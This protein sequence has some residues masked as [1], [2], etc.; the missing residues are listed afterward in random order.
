MKIKRV[1]GYMRN[2]FS[3]DT[4]KIRRTQSK[5]AQYIPR[6]PIKTKFEDFEVIK[7]NEK[8]DQEILKEMSNKMKELENKSKEIIVIFIEQSIHRPLTPIERHE[9]LKDKK[10]IVYI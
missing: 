10:L 8:F 6:K 7:V 3:R 9:L 2:N 1:N 4:D 5:V